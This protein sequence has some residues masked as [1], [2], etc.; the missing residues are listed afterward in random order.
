MYLLTLQEDRKLLTEK[1]SPEPPTLMHLWN[2][3]STKHISTPRLALRAESNNS[4]SAKSDI[5]NYRYGRKPN[6][7]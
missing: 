4:S 7:H 5:G 2:L 3:Q 1:N 6:A